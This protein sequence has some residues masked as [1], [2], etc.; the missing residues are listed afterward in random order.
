VAFHQFQKRKDTTTMVTTDTSASTRS[1]ERREPN[2]SRPPIPLATFLRELTMPDGRKITID[3][4]N[5]GMICE[6]KAE[7]FEGKQATIVAFRFWA[8]PVP[9]IEAYHDLKA[10][11]RGDGANGKA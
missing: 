8:K 5:I 10:W 9:V 7:E 1:P 11:W 2:R 3:K 4:R 6:A